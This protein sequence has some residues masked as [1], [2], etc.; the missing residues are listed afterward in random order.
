MTR[1]QVL[2]L[3][4]GVILLGAAIG[5]AAYWGRPGPVGRA[6][7]F[8]VSR[9]AESIQAPD[10]E[11]PELGGRPARLRDHHGR[12]VVLNFW[13]TWCA[14]CRDEMPALQGLAQELGPEGLAVV[15]VNVKEPPAKVEAFVREHGLRFPVLLDADGRA[16]QAYQVF[17]LPAT[18][19]VDR[20]GALVGTVLGSR[21]WAGPDARAY[22]RQVLAAPEARVDVSRRSRGA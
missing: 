12:V 9:P 17:A 3:S 6:G 10:I 20:R 14:P 13:A 4:A 7:A 18:F 16:G 22:L 8:P 19:V 1:A 2:E 5:V 15:G 21:D 11:L